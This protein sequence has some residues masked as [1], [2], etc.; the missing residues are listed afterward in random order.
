MDNSMRSLLSNPHQIAL[1]T[2]LSIRRGVG[3]EAVEV[4][5]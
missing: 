2:L 1:F 3:G 5:C 4:D